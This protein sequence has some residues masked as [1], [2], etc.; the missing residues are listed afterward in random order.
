MALFV[1]SF[2]ENLYRCNGK[3]S[4]LLTSLSS[5]H[6]FGKNGQKIY[7]SVQIM[8]TNGSYILYALNCN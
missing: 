2:N 3:Q 4:L 8:E 1:S 7:S 5:D 6:L